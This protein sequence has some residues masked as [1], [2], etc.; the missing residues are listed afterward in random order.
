MV[1]EVRVNNSCEKVYPF[2]LSVRC[3][4][5]WSRFIGYVEKSAA[6]H[7]A[8]HTFNLHPGYTKKMVSGGVWRCLAVSGGVKGKKRSFLRSKARSFICYM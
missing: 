5:G 7:L 1:S 8:S 2:L 4:V 6:H 3:V